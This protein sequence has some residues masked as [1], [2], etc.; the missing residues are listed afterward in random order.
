MNKR[1]IAFLVAKIA[2]AG[3]VITW[4]FHKVDASRVWLVVRDAH[5]APIFLALGL[6]FLMIALASWRWHRLLRIFD[7]AIPIRSLFCIVQIGQFFVMFLPGPAGDD[8][9]RML[10][11]SRLAP[12][13]LG[14]ACT[15]V[16]IDRCIGLASVLLLAVCC[17]PW[18]WSVLAS[19][20]QT[21]WIALVIVA[22]GAAACIGGAVFFLAGHPTHR[23]LERRLRSRPAHSLRDEVARI[24]GLSCDN[25]AAIGKVIA[26]AVIT[27]LLNGAL[28]YLA[29]ASVGIKVPF[30]VWLTFAPIVLAASALPITIAGIGVREYLL[31]LFLGLLANVDSA[32]ALAASF[33][34]FSM[35]L[36][37]CLLGGLL[38]V[39]YRPKAK[40]T[41]PDP[42]AMPIV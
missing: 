19:T 1:Q 24:W 11:I 14:E 40:P 4:L 13:R 26:A 31:V 6:C 42:A 7:V 33:V 2:F 32:R 16:V 35:M 9:T 8:L 23:W 41:S 18:Q 29:G 36:A 21:H 3:A 5:R 27:Q 15:T 22:A 30:F 28:F 38:Y 10:Y 34:M 39:F 12:D 25:K 17:V 37:I 20:S